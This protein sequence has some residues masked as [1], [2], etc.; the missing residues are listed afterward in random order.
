MPKYTRSSRGELEKRT[1]NFQHP[2]QMIHFL[3]TVTEEEF[4]PFRN[5]A[6]DYLDGSRA[7]PRRLSRSSLKHILEDKPRNLIPRVVQE[8]ESY[9]DPNEVSILGGGIAEG[10]GTMV[11]E[12]SHLLGLDVLKDA[13]FGAPKRKPVPLTA[14]TAA[15]L[16]DMTYRTVDKRPKKTVGYTRLPNY[17]SNYVSVWQNDTT[18][19]I[20]V[21]VRG[22]KL[23]AKDLIS[24]AKILFGKTNSKLKELDETLFKLEERYPDQKFDI[25]SHS[26][27]SAYVMSELEQHG[28][29]IDD[30]FFFTPASSPLQSNNT[31]DMY[32]NL[33]NA[34]Y[35]LN[36]G[37][38]VGDTLRQRMS[39][40]T[41]QEHV[42]AGDYR[43]APWSAHSLSQW[44]PD[45]IE[46]AYL[47]PTPTYN[48]EDVG[49]LQPDVTTKQDTEL[50]Q[51]KKLS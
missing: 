12:A 35:Y 9:S 31:L 45:Y 32:A 25:A 41:L 36:T 26:L 17:D 7:P 43:Y 24:D 16:T 10:I 8:F 23:S 2:Y 5:L 15:Y 21:T 34:T 27:G 37:D 22:T 19:E 18:S 11:G 40:D 29:K 42:Y 44:Y 47:P 30:L 50:T 46:N 6:K 13:I 39:K 20:I 4:T 38:I 28:S 49:D 1:R 51:D 33:P 3:S 14:E 48:R